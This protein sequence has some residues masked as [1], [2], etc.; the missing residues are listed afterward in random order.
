MRLS[1]TAGPSY[2][3][4]TPSSGNGY[5]D[6]TWFYTR[7]THID[8][9]LRACTSAK[10]LLASTPF[11][12]NKDAYEIIIGD[13]SNTETVIKKNRNGNVQEKEPSANIL[14]CVALRRFWV[15]WADGHVRVGRGRPFDDQIVDWQDGSPINVK[16]VSLTM[17]GNSDDSAEWVIPEEKGL[18]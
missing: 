10:I 13:Q 18:E 16:A 3:A 1:S 4:I 12:A 9:Q 14:S 5:Y 11:D 15:S 8:F 17:Y 6:T 7:S 2:T